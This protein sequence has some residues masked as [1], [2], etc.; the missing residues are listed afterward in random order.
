MR[1][2]LVSVLY[3]QDSGFWILLSTLS[4]PCV[5]TDG[6]FGNMNVTAFLPARLRETKIG[7]LANFLNCVL[8]G[9]QKYY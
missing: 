8:F 7:G 4:T 9:N 6:S 5:D 3:I 1:I 2:I